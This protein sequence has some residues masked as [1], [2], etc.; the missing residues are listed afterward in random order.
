MAYG[1]TKGSGQGTAKITAA[2]PLT[3][4][5]TQASGWDDDSDSRGRILR[6]GD[7]GSGR[8]AVPVTV[9]IS[10]PNTFH[11]WAHT[12][13][14]SVLSTNK[15]AVTDFS[16]EGAPRQVDLPVVANGRL[17]V[18]GISVRLAKKANGGCKD[19]KVTLAY[20]IS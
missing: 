15:C 12:V 8:D 6:G 1:L 17:V 5:G 9:T 2:S 20:G 11:H 16:V 18:R 13:R 14:A 10:N 4:T 3:I 19:A 7:D